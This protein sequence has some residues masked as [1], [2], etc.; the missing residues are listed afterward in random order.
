MRR[1]LPKL[2]Q[3]NCSLCVPRLLT[4]RLLFTLPF[5]IH[6]S[7]THHSSGKVEHFRD[8]TCIQHKSLHS[9][10]DWPA[11]VGTSDHVFTRIFCQY[12][13]KCLSFFICL[14][15]D[16]TYGAVRASIRLALQGRVFLT[17]FHNRCI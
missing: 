17:F 13:V 2:F 5:I 9:R 8:Y 14:S 16:G 1:K 11:Y 6:S 10:D 3:I 4:V 7:F 12:Q 15:L